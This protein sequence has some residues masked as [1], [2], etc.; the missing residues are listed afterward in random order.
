MAP[1][2]QLH[3]VKQH[4]EKGKMRENPKFYRHSVQIDVPETKSHH[5][6]TFKPWELA[7]KTFCYQ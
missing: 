7:S 6:N 5:K 2:G 3:W 1:I 4:N